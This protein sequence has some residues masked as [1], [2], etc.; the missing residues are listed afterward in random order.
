MPC[1]YEGTDAEQEGAMSEHASTP[2]LHEFIVQ[3]NISND[4][5]VYAKL[6]EMGID[7]N[8][9]LHIEPGD[10]EVLAKEEMS[11]PFKVKIKFKSAIKLMQST[12]KPITERIIISM[13]EAEEMN[14]IETAIK[15]TKAMN[16]LLKTHKDQI[17][18]HSKALKKQIDET[19][20]VI[21]N[22][23][24]AQKQS[25]YTKVDEWTQSKLQSTGKEIEDGIESHTVF[26][27]EKRNCDALLRNSANSKERELKI[28][29]MV[30]RS[31][32]NNVLCTKYLESGSL[33]SYI[34]IKTSL[35]DIEFKEDMF[36]DAFGR[37]HTGVDND[38]LVNTYSIDLYDPIPISDDNDGYYVE[39]RWQMT[40]GAVQ[41]EIFNIKYLAMDDEKKSNDMEW[42]LAD[43]KEINHVNNP[44]SPTSVFG[45]AVS[46][47]YLFDKS[48]KY[49]VIL[50]V[51]HPITL[52][53]IQ[54]NIVQFI[55]TTS[56][57]KIE[58]QQHSCRKYFRTFSPSG[59]INENTRRVY[60]SAK[61][62]EFRSNENDWIIFKLKH[63]NTIYHPTKCIVEN[64]YNNSGVNVKKMKLWYGD[65]DKQWFLVNVLNVAN[66]DEKQ[67]FELIYN[68]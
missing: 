54:S 3:Q 63:E 67:E 20:E 5:D 51:K 4:I 7:W 49:Q 52:Q 18:D 36:S 55:R 32:N 62:K 22:R 58:L 64:A 17:K 24:Q 57:V 6:N 8:T 50:D 30:L 65:G 33:I 56:V 46:N 12:Y 37:V 40:G 11:L 23:L 25:L 48:Y 16:K 27:E 61:N 31:F 28:G 26:V 34:K 15:Q 9:L 35:I 59:L 45:V 53:Q 43:I 14:K 13:T 41:S 21:V 38:D 42:M 68:P 39:L 1:L 66:T 47:K 60:A 10:L 19:F 29:Q 2:T 44:N